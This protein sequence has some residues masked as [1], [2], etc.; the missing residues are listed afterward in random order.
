MYKRRFRVVAYPWNSNELDYARIKEYRLKLAME[1]VPRRFQCS[2][3]D[4]SA[5]LETF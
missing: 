1:I 5:T 3:T 2:S 4:A